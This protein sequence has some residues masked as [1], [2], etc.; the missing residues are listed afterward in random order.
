MEQIGKTE[1]RKYFKIK[2]YVTGK[3][4]EIYP[5]EKVHM[6]VFGSTSSF[7]IHHTKSG[8]ILIISPISHKI[9][10]VLKS[11]K[12]FNKMYGSTHGNTIAI[13][14]FD[15]SSGN[16]PIDADYTIRKVK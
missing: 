12:T 15:W 8:E 3:T 9:I 4:F 10:N 6:N 11:G 13:K 16:N 5:G 14:D 7:I 2:D 1:M